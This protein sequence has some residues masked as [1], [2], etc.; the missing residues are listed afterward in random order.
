MAVRCLMGSAGAV[1]DG[2]PNSAHLGSAN[3]GATKRQFE[4]T[5]LI[6]VAQM[7]R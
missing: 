1:P 4:C 5:R 7:W 3:C 6:I 2:L